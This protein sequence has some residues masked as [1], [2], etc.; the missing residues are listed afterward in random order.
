MKYPACKT[1][2]NNRKASKVLFSKM[3]L[4]DRKDEIAFL[5]KALKD[6]K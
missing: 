2:L 3:L 4:I 1:I 6:K 5:E